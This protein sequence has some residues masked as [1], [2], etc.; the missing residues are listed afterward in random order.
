MKWIVY[1]TERTYEVDGTE[2]QAEAE[3]VRQARRHGAVF[4]KAE[5]TAENR[6]AMAA[7]KERHRL[8]T[9]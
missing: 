8:P 1:S 2:E 5:D 4:R 7:W 9:A 6:A 3:R